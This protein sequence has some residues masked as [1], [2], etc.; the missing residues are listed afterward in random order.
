MIVDE[1]LRKNLMSLLTVLLNRNYINEQ[2][3][4]F[5]P[6]LHI[7]GDYDMAIKISSKYKVSCV[8]QPLATYRWHGGNESISHQ[9]LCIKEMERWSMEM[10]ECPEI[11]N[12]IGFQVFLN[13]ITYVKAMFLLMKGETLTAF[14]YCRKLPFGMK[15][16]KLLISFLLPLN[17]IK[18]LKT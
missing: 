16:L 1:L 13:Q 7:M 4:V 3:K 15:K 6:R 14:N 17:I 11:S 5:D 9:E 18:L 10:K 2:E 12:N 8:Q